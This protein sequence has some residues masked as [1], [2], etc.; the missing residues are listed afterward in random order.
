MSS[1]WRQV[2]LAKDWCMVGLREPIVPKIYREVMSGDSNIDEISGEVSCCS[3]QICKGDSWLV[4]N[5]LAE[6]CYGL[7][8]HVK[9][10][11]IL[12]VILEIDGIV[13][14]YPVNLI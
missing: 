11:Q 7:F 1:V 12:I 5:Q 3:P 4:I 9:P 10:L 2:L 14:R 13:L 6:E 8:W